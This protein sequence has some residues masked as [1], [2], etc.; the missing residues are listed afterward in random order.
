M[1]HALAPN[2]SALSTWVPRLMPPSTIG[3]LSV[4]GYYEEVER[5]E[6]IRVRYQDRSGTEIETEMDG[7]L[8][9]CVQHEIDHLDGKL[10]VDYL[11]EAKRSR[12]R[13]RLL[14]DKRHHRAEISM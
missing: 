8:A 1:E 4:P 3:C 5:A 6:H 2:A 7:T 10:F 9:I 14:R 13:K 11:S 12:I